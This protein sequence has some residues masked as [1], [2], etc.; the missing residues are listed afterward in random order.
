MHNQ[1]TDRQRNLETM[2][3][4]KPDR[5]PLT[6]G[7]GRKSTCERWRREGLP[8]DLPP[9]GIPEYAY[10]QAGGTLPWPKGGKSFSVDQRMI[11]QFEEKVIE[12]KADSQI[13]QDWKGN[14]CEISNEFTT[15]YLRNAID[16]V[17]RSWIK[18]PVEDEADWKDMKRRYDP[19]DPSRFPP[20]P[21]KLG[22]EVNAGETFVQIHFNGPFW[23][24]REWTGFEN[25]CMF[26]YDKPKLVAEM[27]EF[28]QEYVAALL[29]KTL[30]YVRPDS[31]HIS[32]DMAYK[33]FSMISPAM[34]R[35]H[36]LPVYKRWGEIIRKAGVPLYGVDS[37][38]FIGELIPIWIDAGMNFCDPIEVAAG[39]DI[40][41]F[42]RQFGK[43]MAYRGGIDKR[44]IAKGGAVIEQ[45]ILRVDPVIRSGGYIPSCDH[46]V[47]HDVSWPN[48]VRYTGLLAKAT[49]W[50]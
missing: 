43:D 23:Q 40:V 4:G 38:G 36:L 24:L 21:E 7:G 2:L 50:L 26:F 44:A 47:P 6:P 34:T 20:D 33:S 14:I 45:E 9:G 18:C 8:A 10:R 15:E 32:E 11:P 39:N 27:L 12:R 46:G 3:F 28:W 42:R 13:V 37:D 35:Q 16:F 31:L 48:F 17:T 19:N 29:E 25:L 5:I 49:G 41:Q 30:R 22:A 1:M